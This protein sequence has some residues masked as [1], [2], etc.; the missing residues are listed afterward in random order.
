MG[1][2]D[3]INKLLEVDPDVKAIVSSGYS[4]D[5][6]LASYEEYGFMGIMP[7]PFD[8]QSISKVLH[9]LLKG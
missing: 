6:V 9:K 3:A 7:K 1:R 2:K 8:F 5:P 4:D